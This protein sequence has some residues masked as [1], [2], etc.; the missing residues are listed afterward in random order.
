MPMEF[1]L[2]TGLHRLFLIQGVLSFTVLQ[3]RHLHEHY[4]QIHLQKSLKTLN[5]L[6]LLI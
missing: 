6:D 1:G 4:I 2:Q 5:T 3:E